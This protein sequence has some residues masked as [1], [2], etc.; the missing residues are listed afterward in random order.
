MLVPR[1][2]IKPP[3]RG[4]SVPFLPSQAALLPLGTSVKRVRRP[5]KAAEL[6]HNQ[7][8]SLLPRRTELLPQPIEPRQ[9]LV[10]LKCR[11]SGPEHSWEFAALRGLAFGIVTADFLDAPPGLRLP[12]DR[13]LDAELALRDADHFVRRVFRDGN[14]GTTRTH[15]TRWSSGRDRSYGRGWTHGTRWRARPH[16][17]VRGR[18][19]GCAIGP[20]QWR[21]PH[22]LAPRRAPNPRTP[23]ARRSPPP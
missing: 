7:A 8:Q 20:V 3:T 22:H 21:G 23:S 18:V 4:F 17:P 13:R 6:R 5:V 19:R 12:R 15:R 2:G 10:E 1:G 9:G 11:G 14:R 16:G